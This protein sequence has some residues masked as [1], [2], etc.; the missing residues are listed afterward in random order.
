[1]FK[2]GLEFL[3]YTHQILGGRLLFLLVENSFIKRWE[4]RDKSES[5]WNRKIKKTDHVKLINLMLTDYTCNSLCIM[6]FLL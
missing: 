4:E 1:M 5:K 3:A 2:N 6:I